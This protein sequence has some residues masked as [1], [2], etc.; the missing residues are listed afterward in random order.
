MAQKKLWKIQSFFYLDLGKKTSV[1]IEPTL[2][3]AKFSMVGKGV[4]II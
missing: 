4:L 3:P 2:P 1:N